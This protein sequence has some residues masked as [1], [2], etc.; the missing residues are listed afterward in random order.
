MKIFFLGLHPLLWKLD[1]PFGS[2]PAATPVTQY[3]RS[4]V[5]EGGRRQHG[6][7]HLVDGLGIRPIDEVPAFAAVGGDG[8]AVVL[9]D[10]GLEDCELN[11]VSER[12]HILK[13]SGTIFKMHFDFLCGGA[14]LRRISGAEQF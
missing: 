8:V 13:V 12:I 9:A 7:D 1:D 14:I 4:S 10:L 3:D 6:G 2:S 5:H 11:L